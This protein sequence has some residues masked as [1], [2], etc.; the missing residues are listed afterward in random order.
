MDEFVDVIIMPFYSRFHYSGLKY[1]IISHVLQL[2]IRNIGATSRRDKRKQ[3]KR[4]QAYQFHD[5]DHRLGY[6]TAKSLDVTSVISLA[7]MDELKKGY[8]DPSEELVI[9]LKTLLNHVASECKIEEYLV[10][11]FLSKYRA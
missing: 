7:E 5:S 1:V 8:A 3:D 2:F 11:P 9:A 6:N 4:K 10:T